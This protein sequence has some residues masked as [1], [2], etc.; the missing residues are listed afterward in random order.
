I[1]EK[2]NEIGFTTKHRDA[3]QFVAC[4]P[5]SPTCMGPRYARLLGTALQGGLI[6]HIDGVT[7]EIEERM[8]ARRASVQPMLDA[9]REAVDAEASAAASPPAQG[10]EPAPGPALPAARKN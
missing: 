6:R 10:G 1:P 2:D 3:W 8:T 4:S 5:Q 7:K 9:F